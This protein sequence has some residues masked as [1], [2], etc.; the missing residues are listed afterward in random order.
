M[1]YTAGNLALV[2]EGA[3]GNLIY[4]YDAGS[5][6]TMATVAASGYFNNTDD[7]LNLVVDDLIFCQCSD[8]DIWLKVSAVSSGSVTTQMVSGEGPDNGVIGSASAALGVGISEIGTGTATAFVLPTPYGGAKVA[9][10]KSGT[11]TA[12]ETFVTD[13]T[14]VTLS[15]AGDRTISINTK[16]NNFTL[17]GVSTTRWRVV[18]GENLTLS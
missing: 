11:A 1:A 5:S 6:D 2:T 14:T 9:V 4:Y 12:G 17:V 13:A 10:F 18:A 3:V 8:G 15:A 16:G 7:D